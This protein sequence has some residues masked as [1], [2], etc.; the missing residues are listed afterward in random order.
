[1]KANEQPVHSQKLMTVSAAIKQL[2]IDNDIAGVVVLHDKAPSDDTVGYIENL[3]HV[4]PS[5]SCAYMDGTKFKIKPPLVDPE[6]PKQE[7]KIIAE[8]VNMLANLRYKT[9]QI[10]Q[11]LTMAEQATRQQF[12]I[13]QPKGNGSII[14]LPGGMNKPPTKLN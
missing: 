9:L 8:T 10:S 13:K 6:N 3:V 4:S 7:K 5:Y 1:M 11:A 12:N 2:L 14:Q